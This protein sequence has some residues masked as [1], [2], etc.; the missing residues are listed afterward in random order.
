MGEGICVNCGS[1]SIS[2]D[3][4]EGESSSSDPGREESFFNDAEVFIELVCL[5]CGTGGHE[6]EHNNYIQSV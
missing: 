3:A 5:R 6:I 4:G 2:N 1:I